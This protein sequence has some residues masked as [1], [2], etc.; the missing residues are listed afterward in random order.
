MEVDDEGRKVDLP[1][2]YDRVIK[3][4]DSDEEISSEEKE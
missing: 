1:D 2:F 3:P 4:E